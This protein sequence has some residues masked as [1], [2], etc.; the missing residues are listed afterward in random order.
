MHTPSAEGHY[1][2]GS[3]IQTYGFAYLVSLLPTPI[4]PSAKAISFCVTKERCTLN[5][6]K[7]ITIRKNEL[8]INLN[9]RYI[10]ICYISNC[11]LTSYMHTMQMYFRSIFLNVICT[12][13]WAY[14]K[15]MDLS[16]FE[17][18]LSWFESL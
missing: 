6:D 9:C 15:F 13:R 3:S 2:V 12:K 8:Q 1:D 7:C 10:S 16:Y 17:Y 18:R 11:K 5:I 4:I 14:D